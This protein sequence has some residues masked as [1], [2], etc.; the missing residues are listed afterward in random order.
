MLLLFCL[1]GNNTLHGQGYNSRALT[2]SSQINRAILPESEIAILDSAQF[3]FSQDTPDSS[4]IKGLEYITNYSNSKVVYPRFAALLDSMF[5][6][7]IRTGTTAEAIRITKT[8]KGVA[9]RR[10]AAFWDNQGEKEK[11]FEI[12]YSALALQKANKDTTQVISTL[13][14]LVDWQVYDFNYEKAD[15]LLEEA[16]SLGGMISD[17]S[18]LMEIYL[19]TGFVS[20][21]TGKFEEAAPYF[22]DVLAW[23]R[24]K[25]ILKDEGQ[26]LEALTWTYMS[27]GKL[28]SAEQYALEAIDVAHKLQQPVF[29]SSIYVTIANVYLGK[30]NWNEAER[31]GD[32]AM[33]IANEV[34]TPQLHFQASNVLNEV[35]E[36]QGRYKESLEL[37]LKTNKL[38]DSLHN[39]SS[40]KALLDQ[41]YKFKYQQQL[42]ID[43]LNYT[44]TIELE[45]ARSSQ[46]TTISWI[47]LAGLLIT[48]L[49][50]VLLWGRYRIT[51]TQKEQL[52][53]ANDELKSLDES[54]SRF[55]ANISHEFRTPL[56]VISG[57]SNLMDESET[58]TLIKSNSHKLLNLVNQILDLSK[59]EA[60]KLSFDLKQADIIPY[61][62]YLLES[63][64]S[65]AESKDITLKFDSAAPH[66]AMDFDDERINSIVT[67]LISNA[68]KFTPRGG[69]VSMEV[70]RKAE[71]LQ[72]DITD[73]GKGIPQENLPHVFD[74]FF[75]VDDSN[76]RPG[77]G[78]GIGLALTKDLVEA[79]GGSITVTST[80]H[81]GST[82]TVKLPIQQ[83]APQAEST[84]L[85]PN[86]NAASTTPVHP[87]AQGP[88]GKAPYRLL[89]VED[90]PD[91][92]SYLKTALGEH[93][94]LLIARD[95]EEGIA[96]A[97]EEVPD[98]ILS[99]VMMPNKDG[100]ELCETLKQDDRTSHIPIVL[101]TAR[102]DAESRISGLARG[103]DAYLPKPFDQKELM[104]RLE[105]LIK[106]RQRL[107]ARY[108]RNTVNSSQ[109]E[110]TEKEDAFIL[111]LRELIQERIE[112]PELNVAALCE[113]IGM[114]RT[115][116][117]NKIKALTG[118]A[119]S[120]FLRKIRMDEAEKLLRETDLQIAEIAFRVGYQAPAYFTKLFVETFNKTPS[121]YRKSRF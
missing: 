22:Q 98:L 85:L 71:L 48:G 65:Y 38:A 116:L 77:E 44:Q 78:T 47:L 107:Q 42:A 79:F 28:D 88:T 120:R 40:R 56:T 80:L 113:L 73:T 119:S 121:E 21:K 2:I 14:Q 111:K 59:L 37:M 30:S 75:Q 67:N 46:R 54:K 81:E 29:L 82:F 5:E 8:K 33:E 10:Q 92:V 41:E 83:Q 53:K 118:L 106:L 20:T 117:H 96:K 101:L 63:F 104:V 76:T 105:N 36:R 17:S 52:D 86:R 60:N 115:Q 90:N 99:D 68:I 58:R 34:N 24:R 39:S 43:S 100:F 3:Y 13:L 1:C 9:L 114:S 50:G 89:I 97:I 45:K 55:F 12:A 32:L 112:D 51:R 108:Q 72:I 84:A 61:L 62:R 66:L 103:A 91:L 25:G 16:T 35:Y 31:Y 64:Q 4:V 87:E 102:S 94:Q 95:G 6:E 7:Q 109:D 18:S 11:A 69:N 74:R 26:A 15:E 19:Y 70:F 93:Y 27:I 23:A 110:T 57:M 49:L